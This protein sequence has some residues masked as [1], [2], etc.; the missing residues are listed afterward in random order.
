M[1]YH[2]DRFMR[3]GSAGE[4]DIQRKT[5]ITTSTDGY[6]LVYSPEHPNTSHYIG[7]H[8]LVMEKYLGRYLESDE[9]VLHKNGDKLDNRMENLELCLRG[10][11]PQPQRVSDLLKWAYEIIDRYK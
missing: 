10:N 9:V 2:Y 1:R 4:V 6:R 7:E 11:H 5:G 3:T 8:R